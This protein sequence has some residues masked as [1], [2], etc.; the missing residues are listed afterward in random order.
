MKTYR[1][2]VPEQS[3]LLPPAPR[4]WLPNGHL[5]VF[6]LDLVRELDLSA[7]E[8]RLQAKDGRG[9]RPY[10]PV[11]MTALLVYAYCT[12]VFSS[13][14]IEKATV[15]DVAFGSWLAA[16]IRT[17]RRSTSSEPRTDANWRACSSKCSRRAC[18]PGL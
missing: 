17:S 9:E 18:Q 15:E 4:D 13:R 10:S 6:V 1:S 3:Y 7:I 8:Q 12:G 16:S 14:G 2:Y 11:M 5:A